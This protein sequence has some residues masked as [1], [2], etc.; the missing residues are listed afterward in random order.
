G[1]GGPDMGEGKS[2]G[3]KVTLAGWIKAVITSIVGLVSGAMLV[4]LTPVVN[5]VIKPSKP[6]ANFSTQVNGL[7]VN[8][9]NRSA[10]GVQGWWDF[11][12]GTALEPFDPKVNNISHTYA[13]P[14]P[15]NVKLSLQNL[16]GE[17]EDR[18]GPLTI[19]ADSNKSAN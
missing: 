4:Y 19:E 1:Q 3:L 5:N 8:F 2:E 18:S 9:N 10:G 11:G 13:K 17:E 12:D 16:I 14:G 7:T 15:Y 6:L